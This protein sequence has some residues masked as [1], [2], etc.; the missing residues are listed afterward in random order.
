MKRHPAS[1]GKQPVDRR[2]HVGHVQAN[3]AQIDIEARLRGVIGIAAVPS[4]TPE[5]LLDQATDFGI[6]ESSRW[7]GF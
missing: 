5:D 2:R 1:F 7:I 6:V 4:G 3:P